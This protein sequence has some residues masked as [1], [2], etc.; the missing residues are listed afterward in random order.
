MYGAENLKQGDIGE[1]GVRVITAA[2]EVDGVMDS[3]DALAK[4]GVLF[5]VGHR[6]EIHL[7][8]I[9]LPLSY[10][11]KLILWIRPTNNFAIYSNHLLIIFYPISYSQRPKTD[12]PIF[13]LSIATSPLA[14]RAV[15]SGAR[16][17]THLFNAMPQLH[18]RDP[19]IIGLLGAGGL[20]STCEV[21]EIPSSG[22]LPSSPHVSLP[23]SPPH[24][25]SSG[26]TTVSSSKLM[27]K[28][29]AL[30][31]GTSAIPGTGAAGSGSGNATPQRKTRDGGAGA[32]EALDD[33]L[34]PPQTPIL[35]PTGAHSLTRRQS[36]KTGGNSG[37][38]MDPTLQRKGMP[39]VTP[40]D[41]YAR[42]YYGLIVD[43]IHSHP[44]SVRVSRNFT[45]ALGGA[46]EF[47]C[48]WLTPHIQKDAFWLQMVSVLY[49]PEVF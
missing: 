5:S 40:G 28:I 9:S 41:T 21:G 24:A 18:H 22:A 11:V 26:N 17:I 30:A 4:R 6:Y 31:L 38:K 20:Y 7:I 10:F 34:T 15:L 3:I 33:L 13:V 37:G 36:T 8:A 2:P 16:L 42:P 27:K 39:S 32:A 48:S 46:A 23:G 29:S 25:I 1:V 12:F 47:S 49:Y 14:T 45:Y 43:G 19:A 35:S 44:N